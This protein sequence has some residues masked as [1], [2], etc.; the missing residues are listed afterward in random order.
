LGA[1]QASKQLR[2]S[3]P[4]FYNYVNGTDLPK[5]EVL[6]DAQKMWNIKW[7]LIDPSEILKSRSVATAEQLLLPFIRSVREEDIEIL[8]VTAGGDSTL[9]VM[10]RI[11]FGAGSHVPPPKKSALSAK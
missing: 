10:L 3:L 8:E 1:R 11:Q 9:R 5:M 6:R 7:E 4:S 2:V